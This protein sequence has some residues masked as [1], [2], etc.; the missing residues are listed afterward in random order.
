MVFAYATHS[1]ALGQSNLQITGDIHGMAEQFIE[2]HF[3]HGVVAPGF[4][5]A[6][7]NIDPWFR[8]L[9]KFE[10]EN[11]WIPEPVLM[12][13]MLAEEVVRVSNHIRNASTT[14]PIKTAIKTITL[15]AKPRERNPAAG[16]R[17]VTVQLTSPRPGWATWGSSAW[18][19]RCSTRSAGRSR[20]RRPS[21]TRL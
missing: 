13:T 18:G 15:P 1:T 19:P 5:G 12:S 21:S 20:R 6:S 3:D 16:D 8:T 17:A 2:K 11:G 7:G 14:G 4:A 9:P 10:T